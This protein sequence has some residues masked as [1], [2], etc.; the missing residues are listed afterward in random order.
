MRTSPPPPYGGPQVILWATNL[1]GE[2]PEVFPRRNRVLYHPMEENDHSGVG[3][4]PKLDSH[5]ADVTSSNR[6]REFVR[7][8]Q[9]ATINFAE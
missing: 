2:I 9:L 4:N 1:R 8:I 5:A 6:R 3:I 7:R